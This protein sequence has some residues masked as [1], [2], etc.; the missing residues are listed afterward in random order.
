MQT[1]TQRAD[2]W[3]TLTQYTAKLKHHPWCVLLQIQKFLSHPNNSTDKR[4]AARTSLLTRVF[5]PININSLWFFIK[6]RACLRSRSTSVRKTADIKEKMYKREKI[7]KR[8]AAE[9]SVSH[10][11]PERLRGWLFFFFSTTEHE[12]GETKYEACSSDR[13]LTG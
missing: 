5:L 4:A 8:C 2:D 13:K 9:Y 1:A 3:Q 7:S 12:D 6:S 11:F 10:L